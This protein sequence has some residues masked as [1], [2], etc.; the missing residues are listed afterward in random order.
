MQTENN[1]IARL[2]RTSTTT[3]TTPRLSHSS[4]KHEKLVFI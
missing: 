1:V 3:A 4:A 2:R